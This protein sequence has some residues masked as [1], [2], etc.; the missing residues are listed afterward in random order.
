MSSKSITDEPISYKRYHNDNDNIKIKILSTNMKHRGVQYEVGKLTKLPDNEVFNPNSNKKSGAGGLYRTTVEYLHWNYIYGTKVGELEL[1][2]IEQDPNFKDVLLARSKARSSSV[3]VK[4]VYCLYEEETYKRYNR[5]MLD[6]QF[7]CIHAIKDDRLDFLKQFQSKMQTERHVPHGDVFRWILLKVKSSRIQLAQM[8]DILTK[9]ILQAKSYELLTW[10][11]E[12][13]PSCEQIMSSIIKTSR[14]PI[15]TKKF[16]PLIIQIMQNKIEPLLYITVILSHPCYDELLDKMYKDESY[17]SVL[18]NAIFKQSS[19]NDSDANDHERDLNK[20]T[21]IFKRVLDLAQNNYPYK[22]LTKILKRKEKIDGDNNNNNNNDFLI[23]ALLPESPEQIE[24]ILEQCVESN[25]GTQKGIS[26]IESSC[27]YITSF[28]R[29]M[30]WNNV[31]LFNSQV[32]STILAKYPSNIINILLGY[33]LVSSETLCWEH[34]LHTWDNDYINDTSISIPKLYDIIKFQLPNAE[35]ICK[36]LIK[37]ALQ[38]ETT[39]TSTFTPEYLSNCFAI[40]LKWWLANYWNPLTAE[41][42]NLL[43]KTCSSIKTPVSNNAILLQT[44]ADTGLKPSDNK[45]LIAC[46]AKNYHIRANYKWLLAFATE[47]HILSKVTPIFYECTDDVTFVLEQL[48]KGKENEDEEGQEEEK[49]DFIFSH[50][51]ILLCLVNKLNYHIVK[52][53]S[54]E[55][56]RLDFETYFLKEFQFKND[57]G[58]TFE[59]NETKEQIQFAL[60]C[61]WKPVDPIL[62]LAVKDSRRENESSN[63]FTTIDSDTDSDVIL[64]LTKDLMDSYLFNMKSHS[65]LTQGEYVITHKSNVLKKK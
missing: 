13:S 9:A 15:N 26:K 38:R 23:K 1:P 40:I 3:I 27:H 2:T 46:L 30:G 41:D 37:L 57:N 51:A 35:S 43:Y 42:I 53:I 24:S 11:L 49:K 34:D 28:A 29:E 14:N 25:Y 33:N 50:R 56:Y 45:T 6:N 47:Q 58:S 52:R 39:H 31:V 4:N 64:P 62:K 61:G 65:I 18:Y 36:Y 63:I 10:L 16:S 44:L 60:Q 12:N 21:S 48:I 17:M 59:W 22:I 55:G 19:N 5:D 32:E 20:T 7:I 8:K 54:E